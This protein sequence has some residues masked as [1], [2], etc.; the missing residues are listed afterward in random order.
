MF[1]GEGK[2]V[3]VAASKQAAR[4]EYARAINTHFGQVLLDLVKAFDRV[5]F[6]ILAREARRHGYPMWLA[7]LAVA[8]YRLQRTIGMGEAHSDTVLATRGKTAGSRTVTTEI[9]IVMIDIMLC[10]MAVFTMVCPCLFVDDTSADMVGPETI[11][12]TQLAGFT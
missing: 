5:P 3:D 7:W 8:T 2:G 11:V 6:H 4:A 10:A 1:A 9:K 12:V